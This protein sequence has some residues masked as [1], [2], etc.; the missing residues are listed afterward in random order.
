MLFFFSL[1]LSCDERDFP[2]MVW[3]RCFERDMDDDGRDVFTPERPIV[4][5][6][7]LITL[8]YFCVINVEGRE[9]FSFFAL[10]IFL[11]FVVGGN[12]ILSNEPRYTCLNSQKE[13]G[14]Y[15]IGVLYSAV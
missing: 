14:I 15:S 9:K 4:D 11:R 6:L 10:K 13:I 7:S 3:R 8:L 2:L 5:L 12:L 1:S